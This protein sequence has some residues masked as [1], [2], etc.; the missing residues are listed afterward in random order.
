MSNAPKPRVLYVEDD[1]QNVDVARLR[2]GRRY[3]LLVATDDRSACRIFRE[4][5]ATLAAILMDVELKGSLLDGVRLTRLLRGTLPAPDLPDYALGIEP[6][7]TPIFIVTAYVGEYP[8]QP[9]LDAGA[10]HFFA[11]PVDFVKLS[12]SLANFAARA[13]ISKFTSNKDTGRP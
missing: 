1:P 3:E 13:A 12:L 10:N 7:Q 8:M 6:V 11:K 2:L 9:M 4:E 5:G